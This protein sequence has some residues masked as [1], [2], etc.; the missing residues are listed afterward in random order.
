MVLFWRNKHSESKTTFLV[1]RKIFP[2]GSKATGWQDAG[3]RSQ[4]HQQL[5]ACCQI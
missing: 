1:A 3:K 2:R 4:T 5:L